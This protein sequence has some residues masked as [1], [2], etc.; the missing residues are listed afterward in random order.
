M[1][2]NARPIEKSDSGTIIV[3]DVNVGEN[4]SKVKSHIGVQLQSSSFLII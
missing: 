4:M 3:A 2:P 1:Q